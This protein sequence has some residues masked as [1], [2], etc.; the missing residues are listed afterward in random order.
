MADL[1]LLLLLAAGPAA[2]L[3]AGVGGQVACCETLQYDTT[4]V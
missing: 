3:E 2:S 1:L 4:S